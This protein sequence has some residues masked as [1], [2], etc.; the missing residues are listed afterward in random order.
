MASKGRSAAEL[1]EAKRGCGNTQFSCVTNLHF[2]TGLQH[3]HVTSRV[4]LS[5]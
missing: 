1:I 3:L 2:N 5:C 4:H